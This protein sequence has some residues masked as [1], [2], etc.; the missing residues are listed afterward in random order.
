MGICAIFSSNPLL[1][2]A[3]RWSLNHMLK[4]EAKATAYLRQKKI[5]KK[6]KE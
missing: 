3:R 5:V 4:K 2:F 6:T 1:N